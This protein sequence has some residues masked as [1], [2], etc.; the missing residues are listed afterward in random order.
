MSRKVRHK[1]DEMRKVILHVY[2]NIEIMKPNSVKY[3]GFVE[4]LNDFLRMKDDTSTK[5]YGKK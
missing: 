5:P 2:R 1:C 3:N 4:I